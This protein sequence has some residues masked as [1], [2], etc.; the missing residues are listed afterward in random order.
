MKKIRNFFSRLRFRP[1][2]YR[3]KNYHTQ[4]ARYMQLGWT[5]NNH[6]LGIDFFF[7]QIVYLKN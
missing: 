7:V 5:N 6:S 4:E 2:M 3:Y 1:I